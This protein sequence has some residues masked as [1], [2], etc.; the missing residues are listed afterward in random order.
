MT[1]RSDNDRPTIEFPCEDYPIRV[2]GDAGQSFQT[3]VLDVF[4][5]H[6]PGFDRAKV[7][8]R[9]SR[10]GRFES[11]CVTIRATGPAQLETLFL[12]LKQNP[13]VKMVL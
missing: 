7:Q 5:R 10:N 2:M 12:D 4:E 6:A 3:F 1:G 11:V 13:A 8:V 9:P